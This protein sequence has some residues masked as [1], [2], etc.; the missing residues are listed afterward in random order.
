MIT[1]PFTGIEMR[2]TWQ[3][4]LMYANKSFLRSYLPSLQAVPMP[5]KAAS[6]VKQQKLSEKPLWGHYVIVYTCV[7]SMITDMNLSSLYLFSKTLW[8]YVNELHNVRVRECL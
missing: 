5:T 1:R 3:R 6:V 2:K 4:L 7:I 8:L